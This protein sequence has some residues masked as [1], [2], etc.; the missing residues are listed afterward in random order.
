VNL[1]ISLLPQNA[2]RLGASQ[3]TQ[4]LT[5]PVVSV[6]TPSLLT[7]FSM[8]TA[9]NT[10]YQLT[11]A[12]LTALQAFTPQGAL[13]PSNMTTWQQ[14]QPSVSQQQQQQQSISQAQQQQQQPQQISLA[15]LSNLV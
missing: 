8:P 7:P 9:Y 15:S 1:S 10:E 2:Q 3:V 11:S 12:D 13:L 5:T 4:P 6:A 14:Q